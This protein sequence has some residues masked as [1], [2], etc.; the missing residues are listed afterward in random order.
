MGTFEISL[1]ALTGSLNPKTMRIK[2]K[3]SVKWL[4]ILVDTS[5]AHNFLDPTVVNRVMESQY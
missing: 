3:I 5:Y 2:G 1:H 4:T